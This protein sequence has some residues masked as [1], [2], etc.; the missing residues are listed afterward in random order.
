[1]R[2]RRTLIFYITGY[3]SKNLMVEEC[4]SCKEIISPGKVSL[5]ISFEYPNY[6]VEKSANIKEEF[7]SAI[8]RG[9]GGL[10]KPSDYLYITSVHASTLYR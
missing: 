2:E 1:M 5:K 4:D 3:I 6:E 7:I 9:G 10:T 8:S